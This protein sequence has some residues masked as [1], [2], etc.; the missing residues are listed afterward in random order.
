MNI[1]NHNPSVSRLAA[2]LLG[3]GVVLAPAFPAGVAVAATPAL[4]DLTVSNVQIKLPA[5]LGPVNVQFKVN[6]QGK[7]EAQNVSV[8]VSLGTDNET[9]QIDKLGAGK[10]KQLTVSVMPPLVRGTNSPPPMVTIIVDP[11]NSIAE[12]NEGNNEAVVPL[13]LNNLPDLVVDKVDIQQYNVTPPE[14]KVTVRIQN[15]GKG[16]APAYEVLAWEQEDPGNPLQFGQPALK[17]GQTN[18]FDFSTQPLHT[19]PARYIVAIDPQN[20]IQ[21][22]NEDNNRGS[23]EKKLKIDDKLP[24]LMVKV[25]KVELTGSGST[26]GLTIMYAIRNQG[27]SDV[28]VPVLVS[29]LQQQHY[30]EGEATIPGGLRKGESNDRTAGF[31]LPQDPTVVYG[32]RLTIT[33]R[34]QST[35]SESNVANNVAVVIIP[36]PRLKIIGS[37]ITNPNPPVL[38]QP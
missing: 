1:I 11:N 23:A 19:D 21:E 12:S 9:A 32:T 17:A 27:G 8:L 37:P 7:A 13:N 18:S 10:S 31:N 14:V 5:A 38:A 3:L 35:I 25:N 15:R 24:D 2:L 33:V 26:R 6:N 28:S 29:L 20:Q 36:D 16:D 22:S 4:P 30:L 34:T